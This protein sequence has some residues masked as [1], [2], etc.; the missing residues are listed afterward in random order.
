MDVSFINPFI[1]ATQETFSMMLNEK[2]TMGK[3]ALKQH[4]YPTYDISGVIGISGQAQGFVA[5]SFPKVA[6]LKVVSQLIGMQLK[7]V[8]QDLTDGIGEMANIIAGNAKKDFHQFT[9]LSIS[10][11]NVIVG[12]NHTLSAPTRTPAILVPFNS[13]FG[14]FSMEVALKTR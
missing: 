2:V 8:G 4:P 6:A 7:V 13:K 10:L 14:E 9:N 3:A 1:R 11:P 12:R 5:V